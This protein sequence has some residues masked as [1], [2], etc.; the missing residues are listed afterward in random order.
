[1]NMLKKLKPDSIRGLLCMCLCVALMV[2]A[3]MVFF[4]FEWNVRHS[5]TCL[6]ASFLFCA[7]VMLVIFW[8]INAMI[9]R[10]EQLADSAEKFGKSPDLVQK[11]IPERGATEIRKT[12]RAFN[13]MQGQIQNLLHERDDMLTAIA[14]DIRTPLSR[15]QMDAEYMSDEHA[16]EHILKNIAEISDILEKGMSL[17]KNGLSAEEPNLVDLVS[18][19][20]DMAEQLSEA[21]TEVR[22]VQP[23]EGSKRICAM[24]RS[25]GL[26]ICLRNLIG[27]GIAYGNGRVTVSVSAT[28]DSACI[29][30]ED[31][32][33]GIPDCC[34]EK[35]LRPFVRLDPS[36]NK[37]SGGMG[38]GLSIAR[39][40]ARLDEGEIMLENIFGGG[41]RARLTFPRHYC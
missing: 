41:L 19:A 38:L 28:E 40:A 36:R 18:F 4:L 26:E 11:K 30:V 37:A 27:N 25:S 35:V 24:V 2:H 39:N 16:R 20:E 14:H 9:Q 22:F 29:D 8:I 15:I 32:G 10:F 5:P 23:A 21:S 6:F 7:A 33:P 3:S 1:M 17:T 12:A 34:L 13:A 31:N